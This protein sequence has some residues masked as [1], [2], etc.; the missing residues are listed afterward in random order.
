MNIE[1]TISE[2]ER[3]TGVSRRNIH[4][5]IKEKLMPPSIGS[6]LSS[7]Y[8]EEH[9]L[10]LMTI[11]IL[12][13]KHLR[14]NGIR[15]TMMEMSLDEMRNLVQ[16]ESSQKDALRMKDV[17]EKFSE[18]NTK[19]ISPNQ[20]GFLKRNL[21]TVHEEEKEQ[22]IV[23][24]STFVNKGFLSKKQVLAVEVDLIQ[25][26]QPSFSVLPTET[27]AK[28]MVE[29]VPWRHIIVS[30]GIELN[31]RDDIFIDNKT[32]IEDFILSLKKS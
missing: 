26:T 21:L 13:R 4:F 28:A 1:Y 2:L 17:L 15:E 5:Y 9:Y 27:E 22:N 8:G 30:E 32:T 11:Q 3:L 14:L 19:I 29:S 12:Q 31:I 10:K 18:L 24:E 23:S 16:H 20:S 6:G 25:Q 7:K